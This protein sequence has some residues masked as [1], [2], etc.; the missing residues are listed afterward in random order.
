MRSTL[1]TAVC[2]LLTACAAAPQRKTLA[3]A[4]P[5]KP[6]VDQ[7]VVTGLPQEIADIAIQAQKLLANYVQY[8]ADAIKVGAHGVAVVRILVL[9]SGAIAN[10]QLVKSSGNATLDGEAI[11]VWERI[12]SAGQTFLVSPELAPGHDKVIFEA[13]I[14]FAL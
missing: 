11:D 9:R 5:P 3:G 14:N 8:P 4:P 12:K 6:L 13:P 10:A 7:V 1:L 2:V